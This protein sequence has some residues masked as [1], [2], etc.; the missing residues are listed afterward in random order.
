MFSFAYPQYL[1]LLLLLP[2]ELLL[3]W[4]LRAWRR[5][6]L[7][8]FGQPLVVRQLAPEVSSVKPWVIL[9]LELLVTL[10]VVI[11]LARPRA[12]SAG[13]TTTTV[14]GIEMMVAIDVSN[15]ML[16]SSTDNPQDVSRL[17]RA[18]M[19]LEKVIDRFKNNKVGI[20]VF[21]GNAYMQMPITGDLSS[22]K[23]F[24]NNITTDAVPTQGTAIGAAIN[25]SVNSFSDSKKSQKAVIVITDGENFEDDA[26][27]AAQ[28]AHKKGIQVDVVGVG[29]SHGAPI[30]MP[31]GTYLTN[32]AGETVTTFLNEDLAREVAEAGGGIYVSGNAADAVETLRKTLDQLAKTD[33]GTVSYTRHD[34]QFPVFAWFALLAIFMW[35]VV[36]ESRMSWLDRF[37]LFNR[38]SKS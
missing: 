21:A 9:G 10:L 23:L 20:V 28:D 11:V 31:D 1:Y 16:A 15:S 30:P 27:A 2:V 6:R 38:N 36:N 13:K 34:E 5:N 4:G 7:E 14:H 32:E 18:K 37:N 17:Q 24:L 22:A 12:G 19:I 29:S 25:M 35:T 3:F 33:L 26:T 8:R